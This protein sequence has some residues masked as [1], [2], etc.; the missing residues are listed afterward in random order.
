MATIRNVL[1]IMVDQ[2]RW[3]HVGA[4]GVSPVLTPHIDVLAR[5]GPLFQNAFVQGPVCGPL[6]DVLLHRPLCHEPWRP[7]EPGAP[8][9][10]RENAR[11]LGPVNTNEA[12]RRS[13]RN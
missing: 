12:H 7:L 1:F 4:Y 5:R 10:C 8:V 11:G 6:A 9:H 2:V 13:A 3:D